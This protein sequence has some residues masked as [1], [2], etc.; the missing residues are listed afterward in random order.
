M[1]VQ[2]IVCRIRSYAAL[3]LFLVAAS[4]LVAGCSTAPPAI[5]SSYKTNADEAILVMQL[6]DRRIVHIVDNKLDPDGVFGEKARLLGN[7]LAGKGSSVDGYAVVVLKKKLPD[8]TH[9]GIHAIS[10]PLYLATV[11][12]C[13]GGNIQTFQTNPGEIV[14][15]GAVPLNGGRRP[16]DHANEGEIQ[17]ARQYLRKNYPSLDADALKAVPLI[18][19]KYADGRGDCTAKK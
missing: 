7:G 6:P 13:S 19:H 12:P 15:I 18:P 9:F 4:A 11:F 5:T 8:S 10:D 1:Q 17:A 14:Y 2:N 3:P 16:M